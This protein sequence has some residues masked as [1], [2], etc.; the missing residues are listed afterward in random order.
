[1][2]IRIHNWHSYEPIAYEFMQVY[3][4]S[5]GGPSKALQMFK[6]VN[7]LRVLCCGGDGTVGWLLDSM[8]KLCYFKYT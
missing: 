2:T 4:I 6:D 5:C 8:G 1:M 7:N 3:D